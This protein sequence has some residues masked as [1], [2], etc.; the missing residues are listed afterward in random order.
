MCVLCTLN[1]ILFNLDEIHGVKIMIKMQKI[2]KNAN[3]FM[4]NLKI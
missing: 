2:V 1:N 4:N 3:I